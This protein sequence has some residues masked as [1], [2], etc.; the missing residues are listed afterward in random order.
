M[1]DLIEEYLVGTGEKTFGIRK[2]GQTP[3]ACFYFI[4]F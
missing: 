2:D 1:T 4:A 3:P